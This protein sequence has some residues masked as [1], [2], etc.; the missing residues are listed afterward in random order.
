MKFRGTLWSVALTVGLLGGGLGGCQRPIARPSEDPAP[1]LLQAEGLE[2]RS[3]PLAHGL[4]RPWSL[5]FLPG[6]DILITERP[7][8]L[9][10]LKGGD[11]KLQERPLGGVPEV[12]AQNQGGLFQVLLHPR[13]AENRL[14]YLSYAKVR[15]DHQDTTAVMRGKL[16]PEGL[17]GSEEIFV[18]DAWSRSPKHYGGK[19]MF[20]KDG[21][22]FLPVGERGSMQ[23]AQDT[24]DHAGKVLRLHDDGSVPKDNPFVGREGFRPEI[25]SYGHRN[26]QGLF[27]H[28]ETGQIWESEHGPKGGDE[29]NLLK[30][31]ANYGWPLVT[32]GI[33]YD[34]QPISDQT[35]MVGMEPPLLHW[36]PSIAPSGLLLYQGSAFPEWKGSLFSGGLALRHLRRVQLENGRPDHQEELLGALKTRIRDV[37][38]G[39]DGLLYVLTDTNTGMLLRLEPASKQ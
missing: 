10:L 28:P 3:V 6:G 33:G 25:Y 4:E 37:V 14:V 29:V 23:R 12:N 24:M 27:Q 20:D 5:A 34:G 8:R 19:M 26:P 32:F 9:R 2:F 7:G 39:P 30:P 22:L 13:F 35:D 18:A 31:G 17:E 21:F 15:P 16:G 38:E 11:G 36:T 1:R